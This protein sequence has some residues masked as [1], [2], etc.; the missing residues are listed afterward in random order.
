MNPRVLIAMVLVSAS[1]F[2]GVI[3]AAAT[4]RDDTSTAKERRFE[5]ATLPAGV[6]APSFRLRDEDGN[7]VTMAEMRGEP[8]LVTFLYTSCED[9][10]PT[11]AQQARSALD[12]LDFDVG[13][14]AISVD[15]E[16]DTER[17]ARAFLSEQ[18]LLGRMRF[19]LGSRAELR[20]V[21]REF[22]VQ[23]QRG[24]LEHSGRFVLVDPMGIQ[25]VSFP[26][27]QA[28]PERLAHDLRLLAGGA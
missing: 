5:G 1:V 11:Q 24:D 27:D 26:V 16:R 14:V 25:R 28:T 12:E 8:L 23:P 7:A 9:T 2:V 6:R 20:E 3:V 13:A 19:V 22:A 18:R 21:W 15:P 17:S 4:Q 10:C